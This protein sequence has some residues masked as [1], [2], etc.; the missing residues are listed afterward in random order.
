M[1]LAIHKALPTAQLLA[2]DLDGTLMPH[3]GS[4]SADDMRAMHH[5]RGRGI[6]LVCATGRSRLMVSQVLSDQHPFHYVIFSTGAGLM[7]WPSQ[8]IVRSERI[9]STLAVETIARLLEQNLSFMV[10][11]PIPDNHRFYYHFGSDHAYTDFPRRVE[12][13]REHALPL[14]SAHWQGLFDEGISQFL[15]VLP[16][17]LSRLRRVASGIPEGLESVR[18]TS[19]LDHRSLWLEVFPRGVSKGSALLG[20]GQRL[21]IPP[22]AM[23]AVGNDYNDRSMLDAVA[24]PLVVS[25]APAA[26]RRRYPT[27]V[28]CEN[29]PVHYLVHRCG[30][31]ER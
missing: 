24:M 31:A 29:S 13:G 5:L 18:I 26:L 22:E 25:N 16:P 1:R 30:L 8:R 19:P 9:A 11:M 2:L 10:H 17:Q 6:A 27:V 4:I 12:N 23:V 20:L 21:G 14:P 7:E 3:Q 28:A 15:V